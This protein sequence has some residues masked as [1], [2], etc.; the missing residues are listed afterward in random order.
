MRT[1][2]LLL[3]PLL[4]ALA[5]H[6]SATDECASALQLQDTVRSSLRSTENELGIRELKSWAAEQKASMDR[7]VAVLE[8]AAAEQKSF[9]EKVVAEQKTASDKAVAEQ[10]TALDKAVVE[11]KNASDK[12]AVEQKTALDKALAK[13]MSF[14][15]K[16]ANA[17]ALAAANAASWANVEVRILLGLGVAGFFF[18]LSNPQRAI[19]MLRLYMGPQ[20]APP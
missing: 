2:L 10:K 12:V 8:R 6:A 3:L 1:L 4:L 20:H 7:A 17:A 18:L 13:Q 5:A 14:A 11:Q 9:M 15:K 16:S 19:A